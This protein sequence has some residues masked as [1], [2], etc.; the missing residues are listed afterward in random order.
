MYLSNDSI[1]DL[2]RQ[3]RTKVLNFTESCD[4]GCGCEKC[5][6]K[7]SHSKAMKEKSIPSR[8]TMKAIH[9]AIKSKR[10]KSEKRKSKLP[11]DMSDINATL[12]SKATQLGEV[13]SEYETFEILKTLCEQNNW[14]VSEENLCYLIVGTR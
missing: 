9:A 7:K 10:Q 12:T 6:E 2:S 14:N 3:W 5:A 1:I 11:V 8:K 4:D 13:F